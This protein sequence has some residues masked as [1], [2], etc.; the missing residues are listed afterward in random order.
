M[1]RRTTPRMQRLRRS[2]SITVG[3]FLRTVLLGKA[4]L[5][6][7]PCGCGRS[8][9]NTRQ[10]SFDQL[11]NCIASTNSKRSQ[12]NNIL[13][14]QCPPLKAQQRIT[15]G[16]AKYGRQNIALHTFVILIGFCI[17]AVVIKSYGQASSGNSNA[18]TSQSPERCVPL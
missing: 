2:A 7:S 13:Q 8:N 17:L 12:Q 10:L 9:T 6:L 1:Q 5:L 14:L 18:R 4:R 11:R 15:M 16:F 3:Q